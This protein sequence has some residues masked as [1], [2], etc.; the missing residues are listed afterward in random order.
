MH[1]APDRAAVTTLSIE[2]SVPPPPTGIQTWPIRA[3]LPRIPLDRW[4]ICIRNVEYGGIVCYAFTLWCATY[5]VGTSSTLDP[6]VS[7]GRVT[8]PGTFFNRGVKTAILRIGTQ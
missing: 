8:T 1:V 2:A 5:R 4:E 3:A 7:R 6:R